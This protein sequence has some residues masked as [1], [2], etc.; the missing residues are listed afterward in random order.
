VKEKGRKQFF[1]EEKNQKTFMSKGFL[2]LFFKKE[3]LPSLFVESKPQIGARNE[4]PINVV[5]RALD[6]ARN[7]ELLGRAGDREVPRDFKS[8]PRI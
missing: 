8:Y 4:L 6:N 3:L 1:S 2:V 7:C 5:S